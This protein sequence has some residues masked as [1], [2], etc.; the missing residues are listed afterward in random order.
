MGISY[1][2]KTIMV[3]I[4]AIAVVCCFSPLAVLADEAEALET[5]KAYLETIPFS[6]NGLIE[7]LV[8]A[9]FTQKEAEYAADNCGADWNEMAV[10]SAASY[11]DTSDYSENGLIRQLESKAEGFTHEQ[12]VYGV[13]VAGKDVD[14]SEMAVRRARFYLR[15]SAFSEK[16]LIRQLE[17]DSVGFTHE[18][19]VYGVEMASENVDWNEM[20]FKRAESILDTSVMSEKSLIRQLESDSVGFTHEQAVYGAEMAGK[21][22]DWNQMAVE[23]AASYL[24]VVSVT[25]SELIEHLESDSE[26]FTHEQAVYAADNCGASWSD[27]ITVLAENLDNLF[28]IK[29]LED[30]F[31]SPLQ[32]TYSD[33]GP[34]TAIETSNFDGVRNI[35]LFSNPDQ[36]HDRNY[37]IKINSGNLENFMFSMDVILN[38]V[39]PAGQAGCFVG[40]INEYPAALQTEELTEVLLYADGMGTGFYRR[41]EHE[42]SGSF[43]RISDAVN[44]RYTLTI[45]RFTG[46]TYAFID[47]M[48]AGQILDSND[49]PFWLVY[50]VSTLKDGD[51]ANCSFD[52]LSLRRVNN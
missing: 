17:S 21:E 41:A 48:Y 40:Y 49:G 7:Q 22:I 32:A 31:M 36:V 47:G 6:R 1:K 12:A 14:W 15:S 19:A 30:N 5:A 44:S 29:G 45:M 46:Q 9:G 26:G 24:R 13:S 8:F 16:G 23:K 52:N 34:E 33:I 4:F 3:I 27:M 38:D 39:F 28:P 51:T 18:Q 2:F 11:L 43:T 50:G 25:R 42:D 20:A 37:I 35:I 10:L